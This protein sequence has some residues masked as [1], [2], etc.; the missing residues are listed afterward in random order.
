[1]KRLPDWQSLEDYRRY[2][3]DGLEP[4]ISLLDYALSEMSPDLLVASTRIFFPDFVRHD[5][6]VFLADQ[7]SVP[8]YENWKGR[9][10]S[11]IQAIEKIMNHVH[12]GEGWGHGFFKLSKQN[13]H[14]VGEV[15]V[16]TWKAGL[17]YEF[18]DMSFEVQ[19]SEPDDV[20]DF[21]ITFWH[22]N[23]AVNQG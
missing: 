9:Y 7:F 22:T 13:L 5:E 15:L 4:V 19:G 14:Y 16:Q 8:F 2:G 20:P 18:P 3:Y 21:I 17:V 10:G 11:N 12:L 1:M 23:P 6:G